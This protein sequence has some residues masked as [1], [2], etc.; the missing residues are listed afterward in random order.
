[1]AVLEGLLNRPSARVA[2]HA[3]I[4]QASGISLGSMGW[5]LRNLVVAGSIKEA[6]KAPF[7]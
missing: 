7:A 4:A 1:M 6:P 2:S 5:S 3:S